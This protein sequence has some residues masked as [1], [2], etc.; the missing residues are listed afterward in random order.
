MMRIDRTI[1]RA[2]STAMHHPIARV[3]MPRLRANERSNAAY[4]T[5]RSQSAAP[6]TTTAVSTASERTSAAVTVT[7]LPKSEAARSPDT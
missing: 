5:R 6:A 3:R 7:M 1:A 2:V 4:I